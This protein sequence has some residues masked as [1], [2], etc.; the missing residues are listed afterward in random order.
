MVAPKTP[1]AQRRS[2]VVVSESVVAVAASAQ[3]G[4]YSSPASPPRILCSRR[5]Y[6]LGISLGQEE[7]RP[8]APSDPVWL[9]RPVSAVAGRVLPALPVLFDATTREARHPVG[10]ASTVCTNRGGGER[11]DLRAIELATPINRGDPIFPLAS[12]IRVATLAV[13]DLG[14]RLSPMRSGQFA[15]DAHRAL[16]LRGLPEQERSVGE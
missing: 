3:Y 4:Q 13:A 1:D 9:R 15:R 16:T 6:G 12:G 5:R 10:Q 7:D 2:G 8:V 14:Y 11:A